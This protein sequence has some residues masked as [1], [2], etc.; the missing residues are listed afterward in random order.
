MRILDGLEMMCFGK[1]KQ[2]ELEYGGKGKYVDPRGEPVAD[3]T[4]NTCYVCTQSYYSRGSDQIAFCPNCGHM[5]RK[6]FTDIKEITE[7]LRGQSFKWLTNKGLKPLI[8]RKFD[9][10][11]ELKFGRDVNDLLRTGSYDKVS[12]LG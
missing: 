6:R 5:D 3:V 1:S 4:D 10:A 7:S 8:V 12:E 11:W 2:F 9:G